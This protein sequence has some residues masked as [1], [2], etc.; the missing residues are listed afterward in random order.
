MNSLNAKKKGVLALL[1]TTLLWGGTFSLISN[2]L[3]D[4]SAL[5]FITVRFTLALVIFLPF[6]FKDLLKIKMF[7]LNAGI[8]LGLIYFASF[9][10]QTI[11]LKFTSAT[12][13]AFITGSFIVFTPFLQ[14]IAEKK[15]LSLGN[16]IGI[17]LVI[18]G[19][20]ILSSKGNSFFSIFNEIG[21]GF[22]VGDFL[23]LA[24]AFLYALY[25]VYLD[26]ISNK[27][28]NYKIL[29]LLQIAVTAVG[30]ILGVFVLNYLGV[31]TPK[32]DL[33][34][35]LIIAVVYTAIFATVITT[36]LQTKYQKRVS[37]A[38]AS[39]IFSFEPIFATIFAVFIIRSESL[40]FASIVGGLFI[41]SGLLVSE[42]LDKRKLNYAEN[43][44]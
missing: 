32:F 42:L 31:E 14:L 15:K 3:H 37:P 19:L 7:D 27:I 23:T 22:S 29:V 6:V 1:V 40:T 30:G 35:R 13:S 2:A 36:F 24:C 21:N 34:N 25:I 8:I 26:I 17:C 4:T 11:G 28:S 16:M 41:F 39:I 9:S 20:I 38:K 10:F 12:K 5:V 44:C 43:A 18:V 33:S